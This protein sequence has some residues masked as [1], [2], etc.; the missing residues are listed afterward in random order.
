MTQSAIEAGLLRDL[1]VS[2]G[3]GY[4]D[5]SWSLRVYYKPLVRLIWLGGVLMFLGGLLAAAGKRYRL[6]RAAERKAV[7]IAA[8]AK[9]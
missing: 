2:L 1:Y 9:A 6:A 3:E 5:G 4:D 8:T 7:E